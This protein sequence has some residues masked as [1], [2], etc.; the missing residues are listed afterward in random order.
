MTNLIALRNEIF[1][2][3]LE[4]DSAF[5]VKGIKVR[6]QDVSHI[7]T[8]CSSPPDNTAIGSHLESSQNNSHR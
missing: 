6:I 1:K 2:R 3:Q 5:L 8:A 4:H 7:V